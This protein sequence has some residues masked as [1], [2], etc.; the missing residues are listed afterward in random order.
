[1]VRWTALVLVIVAVSAVTMGLTARE[2]GGW[3]ELR[4]RQFSY[5][6]STRYMAAILPTAVLATV[7]IDPTNDRHGADW[8]LGVGTLLVMYFGSLWALHRNN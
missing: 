8:A 6:V 2:V 4:T 3:R 5:G 1:M 7:V